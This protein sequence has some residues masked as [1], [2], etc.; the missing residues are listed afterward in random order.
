MIEPIL[1]ARPGLEIAPLCRQAVSTRLSEV[2]WPPCHRAAQLIFDTLASAERWTIDELT[3]AEVRRR[4]LGRLYEEMPDLRDFLALAAESLDQHGAVILEAIPASNPTL[5]I[6][7]TAFGDISD[8][9]NGHPNTLVW[10]VRP[11]S[12]SGAIR[13]QR[14]DEFPLHTD[15]A[16][17]DHPHRF[18]G[19]GCVKPSANGDGVSLLVSAAGSR[20]KLCEAGGENQFQLLH[21]ACFPFA[22]TSSDGFPVA[23]RPIFES[24]GA[25]LKVRYRGPLVRRGLALV[26]RRLDAAHLDAL[27]AFEA[28][29]RCP[30]LPARVLL[31]RH[32]LLVFDNR[33]VL[34]G[35]SATH[36]GSG[37]HLKRLRLRGRPGSLAST[38][39]PNRDLLEE[40]GP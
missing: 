25:K 2:I 1:W 12:S 10:D 26:G 28:V 20:E 36:L 14:P 18:V 19:L 8:E 23:F 38:D 24:M 5:L 17:L 37:R 4:V 39:P 30:S 13:S 22:S 15:S 29:L 9:D 31:K 11:S 35:R 34:H 16:H 40:N 7:L 3:D 21:D 6:T 32:D 33:R 27:E